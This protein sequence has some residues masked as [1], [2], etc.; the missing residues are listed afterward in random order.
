[1]NVAN[2]E[3]N[4]EEVSGLLKSISND[5]RLKILCALQNGEKSVGNLES[6]VGLSQSALSQHLARLR[7]DGLVKTRRDAQTIFYSTKGDKLSVL[8]TTL[9]RLYEEQ[10][11]LGDTST[12]LH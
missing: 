7:R 11:N 10:K 8:L 3:T 6:I 2:L 12:A 9:S 4:L 5:K 1:M